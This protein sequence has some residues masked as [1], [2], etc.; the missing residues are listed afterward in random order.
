MSRTPTPKKNKKTKA[1][2]PKPTAIQR[3]PLALGAFYV[4]PTPPQPPSKRPQPLRVYLSADDMKEMNLF[5]GDLV[6]VSAGT[7]PAL[8]IAWPSTVA[9]CNM[10]AAP[11]LLDN[12]ALKQDDVAQVEKSRT[13]VQDLEMVHVCIVE[14]QGH[15]PDLSFSLY[16]KEILVDLEFAA[17]GQI[18][19]TKYENV[20]V[21]LRVSLPLEQDAYI[22][23]VQRTTKLGF[24]ESLT[25]TKTAT[26]VS[27]DSIGGLDEPI[28]EI[29]QM[30]ETPLLYPERFTKFGLAPPKG[31][32]LHGPP[33]TGKTLIARAVA[34]QTKAHVIVVNGPE[35]MGKY[36][37]ETELKLKQIFDEASSKSPSVIILDELDSLCPSRDDT[38][39]ELEKR[40]VASLLTLMDGSDQ[41]DLQDRPRVVVVATTNRPNAIDPALRRPGRF[42]REF[43]IGIP[44]AAARL[45]ILTVLFRGLKHNLTASELEAI[46]A[47]THGYVG[48]DLALVCQEAG[49]L[50]IQRLRKLHVDIDDDRLSADDRFIIESQ[51]VETGLGHVRPS[52]VREIM[53][54]VPKVYWHEIGGQD[55]VKQKLKEAVEWP[56]KHPDVFIKFNIRPPKGLLLYGPPGCSKT[57]MAKA[58]ATEAGLNF[59]AV[60][61]PELFSKWVGESE[62]AVQQIFKK[63]R[64]ASPSIIFFDE[65]DAL[66]V[67]RSGEDSSVADRVLS[68][69]L[70]EMDGIEPLVNVTIVAATNRP[71]IIDSA[72]LR[73]GRI[74]SILYVAPPDLASRTSIFSLHLAKIPSADAVDPVELAR[75]TDGFSGAETVA[76]CQNAAML[77]LEE[78]LDAQFVEVRHFREAIAKTTRRITPEMIEFYKQ[79]QQRSGLN[80]L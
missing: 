46:A 25:Q 26:V 58:L 53:L 70:S 17:H 74:D 40:I 6:W 7:N 18:V 37:G 34:S 8:G 56:L 15:A 80:S 20:P 51:D 57:L 69:L 28:R 49:L 79:F 77:A 2:S 78:S 54:E 45:D 76:V 30:I 5:A 63:A 42:D 59:L 41:T 3:P 60:K 19:D 48:A 38:G 27:F 75:L 24:E 67:K 4:T 71:D 47:K 44:S 1:E 21:R 14:P 62:K 73:P 32:L 39:S 68:Q 65:I 72:L 10:Q 23:H 43:E 22:G 64:A 61:G 13:P 29:R 50:A 35:I 9:R 55:D 11:V 12:A 31:V 36:Y 16:V 66:A 33:G 52:V